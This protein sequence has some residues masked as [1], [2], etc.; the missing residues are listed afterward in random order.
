MKILTT[1]DCQCV[2]HDA[3]NDRN[4]IYQNQRQKF[5]ISENCLVLQVKDQDNFFCAPF[6][7]ATT[8]LVKVKTTLATESIQSTLVPNFY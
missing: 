1:T 6:V 8:D 3:L 5:P 2:T 7:C 4:E